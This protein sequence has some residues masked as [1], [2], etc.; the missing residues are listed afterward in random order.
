MVYIEQ[1]DRIQRAKY[2]LSHSCVPEEMQIIEIEY[3]T[4]GINYGEESR[5]EKQY[6]GWQE[7]LS[8]NA[9]TYWT[10]TIKKSL[11]SNKRRILMNIFDLI[12]Q[13][14][15]VTTA[16]L[17]NSVCVS[18]KNNN[19]MR[20]VYVSRQDLMNY[21]GGAVSSPILEDKICRNIWNQYQKA[22]DHTLLKRN[23]KE[24]C[25]P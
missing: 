21:N 3:P 4:G 6:F 20:D 23:I 2:M 9:K 25:K 13:G 18:F 22:F 5:E 19:F 11:G 1:S 7:D 17:E 14:F 8:Y 10:N 15:V 12:A 16:N 24:L